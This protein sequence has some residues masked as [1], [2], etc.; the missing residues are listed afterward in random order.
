VPGLGAF[1]KGSAALKWSPTFGNDTNGVILTM[2]DWPGRLDMNEKYMLTQSSMVFYTMALNYPDLL[3]QLAK[4][5]PA[6]TPVAVASFAGDAHKQ[7]VIRGTVGSFLKEVDYKALPEE[8]HTFF[9][10]KFLK[11][12]QS[13]NGKLATGK[14]WT[15][16]MD[17]LTHPGGPN[18][19]AGA[20]I[21]GDAEDSD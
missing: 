4:H 20:D 18:S 12:G 5:Y 8:M 1:E 3:A 21:C 14:D 19:C 16:V 7:K 10:G 15:K 9:V 6:D 17:S 11:C 2:G 13:R